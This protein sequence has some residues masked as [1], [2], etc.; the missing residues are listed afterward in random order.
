MSMTVNLVPLSAV[1]TRYTVFGAGSVGTVL[2]GLLADG[3]VD[4]RLAG[5]GAVSD[6]VLEGNGETVRTR[7][8]VVNETEGTILLCV[9]E[10]DVAELCAGWAGR[11]VVTL[12]NGVTAEKAAAQWCDVIGGVWRFTCELLA[13]GHARFTR[14]GRVIVQ[15]T[16]LPLADDLRR[17]GLDV[18]ESDDIGADVRLKLCL[19]LASTPNALIRPADHATSAFGEIKARLLEEAR[20]VLAA[21]GLSV[22]PGAGDRTLD[23]EIELHRQTGGGSRCRIGMVHNDTWRTL[24]RCR[25]PKERY[26]TA[27]ARWGAAPQNRAMGALLDRATGPECYTAREVLAALDEALIQP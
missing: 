16:A 2:A 6:L 19:N 18:G 10:T 14:R 1:P 17:A 24:S 9:H 7:V 25:K 22:D 21:A 3:G 4:V 11:T 15:R 12:C 13:P 23:E 26:H 20:D 8:P 27:V 5:R